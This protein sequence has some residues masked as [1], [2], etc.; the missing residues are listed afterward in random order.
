MYVYEL[1]LWCGSGVFFLV[2]VVVVGGKKMK[3]QEILV[4]LFSCHFGLSGIL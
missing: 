3:M 1:V 4:W 2:F